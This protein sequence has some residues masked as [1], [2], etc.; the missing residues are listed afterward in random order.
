MTPKSKS[1][2]TR[3]IRLFVI[4]LLVG[5]FVLAPSTN[6]FAQ[7]PKK[8][9][10]TK[11]VKAAAGPRRQLATII[12]AGLGGAVLGLSTL[13]FYE[14]PQD[15]LSNIAIGFAI[16]LITGTVYATYQVAT[17]PGEYLGASA[18]QIQDLKQLEFM[19]VESKR[20]SLVADQTPVV[21]WTYTF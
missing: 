7:A 3:V 13:S 2:M 10:D 16:G 1:K 9:G 21:S 20:A 11:Q 6:V 17:E 18:D 15:K 4:A 19:Q 12:F 5:L 8:E 14:R